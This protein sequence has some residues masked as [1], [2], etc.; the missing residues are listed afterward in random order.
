[1]GLMWAH[2]FDRSSGFYPLFRSPNF[3]NLIFPA[4]YN[5]RNCATVCHISVIFCPSI[6]GVMVWG[7]FLDTM[8]EKR[9]WYAVTVKVII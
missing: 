3:D 4:S 8:S 7:L 5:P 6:C 1:M 9:Y 2:R